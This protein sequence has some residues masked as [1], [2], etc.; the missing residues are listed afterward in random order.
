MIEALINFPNLLL[1]SPIPLLT[2]VCFVVVWRTLR[3]LPRAGDQFCWVPFAGTVAIFILAFLGLAY[4]L[5]PNLVISP[6]ASGVYLGDPTRLRQVVCNL[7][8]NALKFTDR[9]S[10]QGGG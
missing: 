9:G 8:S 5:Y 7:I 2:A 3:T 6:H 10:V 4:S 1:L